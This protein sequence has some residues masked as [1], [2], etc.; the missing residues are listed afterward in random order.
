MFKE[1]ILVIEDDAQIQNFIVYTLENEGFSVESMT[2]GKDGIYYMVRNK[3]I[4][5]A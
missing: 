3:E 2:N 1:K 4:L 5:Y